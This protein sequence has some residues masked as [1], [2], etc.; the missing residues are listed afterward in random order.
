MGSWSESVK[1]EDQRLQHLR[2]S[3]SGQHIESFNAFCRWCDDFMPFI[4]S[5]PAD[6]EHVA[7]YIISIAKDSKS[8]SKIQSAIH[9]ISWAYQLAGFQDPCVS[10]L[11]QLTKEIASKPIVK[12]E[13]IT[14]DHLKLLVQRYRSDIIRLICKL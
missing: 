11:V 4:S 9:V 7:L 2:K 12:K 3:K 6:E 5:L 13:P 14:P 10:T 8:S 1:F